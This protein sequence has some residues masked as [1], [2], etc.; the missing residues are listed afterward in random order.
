[1]EWAGSMVRVLVTGSHGSLGRVACTAAK[2]AGHFIATHKG[3]AGTTK[4]LLIGHLDGLVL[5][6]MLFSLSVVSFPLLLDRDVDCVTAMI[7][8]VRAVTTSPLPLLGWAVLVVVVLVVSVLPTFLGLLVTLPVL[9]HATWHL[10]R[11]IVA[12]QDATAIRAV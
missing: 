7:T 2:R 12:P 6:L 8:S 11:R 9:G 1:M 4:M 5:S 10:Y 3:R